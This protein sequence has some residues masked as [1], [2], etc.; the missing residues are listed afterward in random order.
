MF[1]QE[2]ALHENFENKKARYVLKRTVPGNAC[3][4]IALIM[5]EANLL[6]RNFYRIDK[7]FR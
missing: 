4:K 7:P 5:N 1:I 6:F 3:D 2:H